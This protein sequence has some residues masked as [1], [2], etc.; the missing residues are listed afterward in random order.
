MDEKKKWKKEEIREL[1]EKNDKA[2]MR[3]L[4][5]IYSLQTDS[6]RRIEETAEH[7]GVGFSGT[8][9]KFLSSLAK[10]VLEKGRL[11]EKQMLYARK[12]ML[13]YAGQLTKVSNGQLQVGELAKR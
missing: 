6:E 8:D 7:N 5:V 9:A 12:K 1:L 13:K 10:Q 2:V 4:V 3:G 11:S